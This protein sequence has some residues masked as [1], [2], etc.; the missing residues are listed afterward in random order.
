M[1]EG[2]R[3]TGKVTPAMQDSTSSSQTNQFVCLTQILAAVGL[4]T[5]IMLGI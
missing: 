2:R 3:E 1:N 5:E 4:S